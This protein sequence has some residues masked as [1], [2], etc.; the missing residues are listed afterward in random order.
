MDLSN[1]DVKSAADKGADLHLK[2]PGTGE[3]LYCS[4]G[5]PFVIRLLGRD[6]KAVQEALKTV[7]KAHTE[8][9]VD[10]DERG[11]LM[12]CSTIV[13]WSDEMELDGEKL[14]YSP[15]NAKRLLSD[16]RTDWMAE[17]ITP[18]TL[19]RRNFAQNMK[20]N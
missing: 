9:E 20:G 13:G 6:A 18:F 5:S 8:G 11:L 12:I 7:N 3:H 10:E 2:N 15:E 19:S 1:F 17:Q 14:P 4:D 16:P